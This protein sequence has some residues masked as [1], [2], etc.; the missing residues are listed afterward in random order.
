MRSILTPLIFALAAALVAWLYPRFLSPDDGSARQRHIRRRELPRLFRAFKKQAADE[1][2]AGVIVPTGVGDTAEAPYIQFSM[3]RGRVG[4][5][6]LLNT[7][8]GLADEERFVSLAKSLGLPML[9]REQNG[10]KYLRVERG[11]LLALAD[12]VLGDLYG[13]KESDLLN[14]QTSG[15][16]WSEA[17]RA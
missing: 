17:V 4:L 15:I 14:L 12:A 7:Q 3:E 1:S 8:Q 5:D 9:E 13:V 10:V 6:W 11:D 2:Y 16:E